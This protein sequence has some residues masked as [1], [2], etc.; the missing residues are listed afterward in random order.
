MHTVLLHLEQY[1]L[2]MIIYIIIMHTTSVAS[3]VIVLSQYAQLRIIIL[4]FAYCTY[5][6]RACSVCIYNIRRT[7]YINISRH[8]PA[9]ILINYYLFIILFLSLLAFSSTSTHETMAGKRKRPKSSV[10]PA[11]QH[12]LERTDQ[13]A[14]LVKFAQK[15]IINIS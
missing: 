8:A 15:P 10:T 5:V 3:R 11:D 9:V 14:K 1:E 7:S 2:I 13:Y 6:L 4:Y 12:K